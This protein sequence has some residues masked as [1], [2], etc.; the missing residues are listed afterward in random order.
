MKQ[1][2]QLRELFRMADEIDG[3]LASDCVLMIRPKSKLAATRL[4]FALRCLMALDFGPSLLEKGIGASYTNYSL[5]LRYSE[6]AGK[7]DGYAEAIP[8]EPA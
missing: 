8:F 1:V 4:L 3:L 7:L 5:R 6:E 2:D